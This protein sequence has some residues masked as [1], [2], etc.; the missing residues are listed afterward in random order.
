MVLAQLVRLLTK[1]SGV[2]ILTW[3]FGISRVIVSDDLP[4][5]MK[6]ETLVFGTK[7]EQR[8]C[9]DFLFPFRFKMVT[10]MRVF[11]QLPKR[12]NRFSLN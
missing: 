7:A 10:V 3:G 9:K 6:F 11:S 12:F 4:I 2:F 1:R 8:L 5:L